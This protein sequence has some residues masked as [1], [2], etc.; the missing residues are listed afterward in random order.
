MSSSLC[1]ALA[2]WRVAGAF[3]LCAYG[4][5]GGG[6]GLFWGAEEA[7][8]RYL[9]LRPAGP[10]ARTLLAHERKAAV[11]Y[12]S[13]VLVHAGIASRDILTQHLT[14]NASC[15]AGGGGG[16]AVADVY[17]QNAHR[18]EKLQRK[19][20]LWEGWGWGVGWDGGAG[21]QARW[22]REKTRELEQMQREG[23]SDTL[24]I[25]ND[26]NLQLSQWFEGTRPVLPPALRARDGLLWFVPPPPSLLSC[27]MVG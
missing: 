23:H 11:V 13:T 10:L 12:G 22:E 26:L 6:G 27:S 17:T 7:H 9:A 8:A 5:N 25:L 3:G 19:E 2:K 24:D 4:G 15:V 14:Y 16:T 21:R 20:E 1:D 18:L